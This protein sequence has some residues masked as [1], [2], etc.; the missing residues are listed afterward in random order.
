MSSEFEINKVYAISTNDINE[1]E[2]F[3]NQEHDDA[4]YIVDVKYQPVYDPKQE[5]VIHNVIFLYS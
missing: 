3:V 2:Q 5:K 1:I 4:Y